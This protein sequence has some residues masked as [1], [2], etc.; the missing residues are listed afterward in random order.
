MNAEQKERAT[1]KI[2]ST[3]KCIIPFTTAE[4]A[5]ILTSLN[6]D[7]CELEVAQDLDQ[8]I[9]V[10]KVE[11]TGGTDARAPIATGVITTDNLS[12]AT[13]CTFTSSLSVNTNYY[14]EDPAKITG[15][16]IEDPGEL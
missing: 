9:I 3:D 15:R 5:F 8:G 13:E 7:E 16:R 14:V 6:F 4:D 11:I 1:V 10:I 2:G 12:F